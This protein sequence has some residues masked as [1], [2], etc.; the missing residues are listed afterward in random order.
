MSSPREEKGKT[1]ALFR[2]WDIFV[3]LLVLALVATALYMV[4]A[5]SK[6]QTAEVFLDGEK[7][8]TIRLDQDKVIPLDHLTIHVEKG[9][10]WVEDADC[11]DKICEKT[12]RISKK[13]QSI[14][15]L[16]NRVVI[17]ILGKGEVEAIT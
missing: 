7:V 5:P 11:P 17:K 8:M 16:P 2:V 14:V 1:Y 3:L 15:C 10:L 4:L 6:G 9:A 13:G 12:G